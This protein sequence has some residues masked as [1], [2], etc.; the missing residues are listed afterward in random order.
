MLKP[1]KTFWVSTRGVF[2]LPLAPAL[3]IYVGFLWVIPISMINPFRSL[4]LVSLGLSNTE[5]GLYS[6]IFIPFGLICLWVGGYLSDT[7]GRNKTL[8]LFDVLSWGGYC[9]C[10]TFAANKWWGAAALF[11]IALNLGSGPAYQCLLNE[12]VLSS[13]RTVVYSVLQIV[14]LSAGLLFFPLL[15]GYWKE[16]KGLSVGCHEM[17]CLFLVLIIFGIS[18]RTI[19]IPHSGIFERIP[20]TWKHG[21]RE[22]FEQYAATFKNLLKKPGVVVFLGAKILDEWML[23]TWM[24]YSSLYFVQHLGLKDT[25]LSLL[26]QV[27]AYA[28]CGFLFLFTSRLSTQQMLKLLGLDQVLGFLALAVL[29]IPLGGF[30]SPF[31]ICLLSAVL[32]A[33]SSSFYYSVGTAVLMNVIGEKER[34][35]VVAVSVT[36]FQLGVW[37]L[38]S[39][40]A[41]L[42][43]NISPMILL[44]FMMA[45]RIIDFFLLRKVVVA[46]QSPDFN[47]SEKS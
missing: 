28:S 7:W 34:A 16:Q 38:G 9:F 31:W 35:K 20:P 29:F 33:I 10:M 41:F 30:W 24:I 43:G 36:I 47:L 45:A 18:I 11:F 32:G 2:S 46:L 4:Y 5:V 23:A 21:F 3:T 8:C 1:L 12:G 15:G 25:S 26:A 6:F 13:K 19:F 27:S 44:L 17:F 42:Y 37:I 39:L 14:N 40:S 22:G